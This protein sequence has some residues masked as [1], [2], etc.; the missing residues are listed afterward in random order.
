MHSLTSGCSVAHSLVQKTAHGFLV[1]VVED[2]GARRA[3]TAQA[4]VTGALAG[5]KSRVGP[6][7]SLLQLLTELDCLVLPPDIQQLVARGQ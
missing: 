3:S 6:H 7:Q 2:N 1:D 4:F 5:E